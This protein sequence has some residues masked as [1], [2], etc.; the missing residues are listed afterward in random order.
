MDRKLSLVVVVMMM[1]MILCNGA[2]A[3]ERA[4]LV[5]RGAARKAPKIRFAVKTAGGEHDARASYDEETGELRLAMDIK[6]MQALFPHLSFF[7]ENGKRVPVVG[8]RASMRLRKDHTLYLAT[9]PSEWFVHD[10]IEVGH[11]RRLPDV[12]EDGRDLWIETVSV[13]PR[14]FVIDDFLDEEEC[15]EMID[16]ARPNLVPSH[17][18]VNGA[19]VYTEGRT[20]TQSY[21]RQQEHAI[22]TDLTQRGVRLARMETIGLEEALQVAHYRPGDHYHCHFDAYPETPLQEEKNRFLTLLVYLND[23]EEGGETAFPMADSSWQ[24]GDPYECTNCSKIEV[25]VKPK[26]GRAVLFYNLNAPRHMNGD[27]D[28]RSKHIGCDVISGE[29][30]IANLWLW[31]KFVDWRNFERFSGRPVPGPLV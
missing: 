8:S 2:M 13:S 5:Q 20:S 25:R 1:M 10:P 14:V 11:R 22:A 15:R 19:V 27:R 26:R 30:Y 28:E 4:S 12:H 24:P 7:A 31:N 18:H 17:T 21:L 9:Q 16:L 6:F 3:E 29:K 23:V